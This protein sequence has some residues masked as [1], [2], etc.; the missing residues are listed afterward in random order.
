[1][2]QTI[3]LFKNDEIS[4]QGFDVIQLDHW[5]FSNCFELYY[6]RFIYHSVAIYPNERSWHLD[7]DNKNMWDLESKCKTIFTGKKKLQ[8]TLI[9]ATTILIMQ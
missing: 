1:M 7:I 3:D 8:L 2:E 9:N 4:E 6:N 5:E